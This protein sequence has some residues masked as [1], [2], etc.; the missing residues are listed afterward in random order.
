MY[1][2][3]NPFRTTTLLIL[4]GTALLISGQIQAAGISGNSIEVITVVSEQQSI[5]QPISATEG[6][7]LPEQLANR[8]ASRPAELLE[9]TP[10][11]IATQH[12]GEGKANQYFLRGFNL[13]HGTDF[14]VTVDGMPVNMRSHGHGQG[15]LDINFLIPELV[16]TLA[17]R[18]GPYYAGVGDFSAAGSADFHYHDTLDKSLI[19]LEAGKDDYYRGLAAGSF[20]AGAGNI[21]AGLSYTAY[22][23]PWDMP[24]DIGKV[25]GLVKYNQGDQANGLSL[26]GMAYDNAWNASDQIPRRAVDSGLISNRG[27]IDP[28]VG[29]TTHRYSLSTDW[30]AVIGDNHWHASA[31][32][33]DYK[34]QLYSNF[35]YLLGDPVNGDQFEQF[36]DRRIYGGSGHLHHPFRFATFEGEMQYGI[37]TRIDRIDT[38]GLYLTSARQRLSTVREDDVAESS[39]SAYLQADVPW[40]G[41]FRAIYGARIDYYNFDVASDLAANAG[42]ADDAIISP[43]ASFILGP[44]NATE[45][46]FNVGKGFHSNDARG[47]TITVDP[48]NPLVAVDS[49]EPLAAAWGGDFGIRTIAI[50]KLQLAGSIW[51]LELESELV[52]VG[53]GG[54]TEASGRSKRHGLELGAVYTPAE[55]LIIDA[56]YAWAHSRL[57][58]EVDDRIPNAV[59][60]VVSLGIS[61]VDLGQWSGGLRWRHFGSAPLIEDNSIRSDPTS[62]L[63]G[64]ISYALTETLCVTLAG[65]NLFDSND[66]D[67]TYFYESQLAGEIQP[68][69]DIHFHPVEPGNFR[70]FITLE[71]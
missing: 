8:P 48:L 37:E 21:L 3:N 30:R 66:N 12:S 33:I 26:T 7:V 25:N 43:K 58:D 5:G 23:G 49:V 57:A 20:T 16:N 61:V 59:S 54:A 18:K 1:L 64:Q 32:V 29:G 38:V 27:F 46:F 50:D 52:Y 35:T 36:D 10:G 6:L 60:N 69:E 13:D 9:F 31:F 51:A 62:V 65:Y 45:L 47:T 53:D 17:Y 41:W 24:Q 15:Y 22:D 71:L 19:R 63:N 28:T 2:S 14:S 11:L 70:L 56:D 68:V 40:T 39:Y 4:T 44:W 42:E 34:L 55:W 67:I